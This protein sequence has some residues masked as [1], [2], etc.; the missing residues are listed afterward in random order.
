MKKQPLTDLERLAVRRQPE[1]SPIMHQDWS[2]LLFMHWRIDEKLLRPLIP[3]HLSID[4]FDGSAWIGITPFT[5][6][7]MRALPPFIPALPGVSSM[8]ELNVRTYVYMDDVP[9]VWFFSLDA[10]SSLAVMGARMLYGLPYYNADI[11]MDREEDTVDYS[12][13][14][15]DEPTAEFDA[16]WTI[17]EELPYAHPGTLEF[18]LVE[19]Y[20]LYAEKNGEIYSARIYHEP[21]PLREAVLSSLSS[22]MIESLGLPTPEGEPLLHF[23]EGVSV[24][25]WPLAHAE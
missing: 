5:I 16:V 22:G 13:T 11:S 12:L 10:S 2:S 17:G 20:C 7:T 3:R 23:S 6:P 21:W 24:D 25:I 15:T 18:F 1:G 4:T 8:H 14:R 19:R 9:G